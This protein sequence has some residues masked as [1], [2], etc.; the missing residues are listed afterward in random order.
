MFRPLFVGF[1]LVL[2]AGVL[3]PRPGIAQKPT[4][5]AGTDLVSLGVTVSDRRSNF[6][7][8]LTR[9]DLE[10]LEDGKTQAIEYFARGDAVDAAPEL[11]VGLLFDTSGS[12][13]A[14]IALSRSAAVRFLNTLPEAK[15]ITLVDFDTEV[16][17]AKY[18]QQDFPRLVERIR[19]RKPSG[20]TAMYDALGVYLDGASSMQGRK[21]L[22]IFTDGGDTN[23][24][25]RFGDVITLV[26][27]SDVTVYS[28]GFLANQPGSVR[29]EQ[30]MRLTQIAGESGGE[31]FFPSEM[32]QIEQAYDRI[33]AQIRAQYTIGYISTNT[34]TDGSWRK[35]EIKLRRPNARDLRVQT[36]R[37]YFAPYRK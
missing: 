33:L 12:M 23:S 15:D 13:G 4:F 19:S 8:D 7:T 22:V 35:V 26:R 36:R 20:F 1:S 11:H 25:I 32:K 2:A 14:D 21:I 27:A 28:V 16:R 37:G 18:G 17:V 30:R 9:D 31:A 34:A 29:T 10:I 24:A 5:R 6:L 3:T